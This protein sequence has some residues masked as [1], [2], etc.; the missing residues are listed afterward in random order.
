M[1]GG[2]MGLNAFSNIPDYVDFCIQ[3]SLTP[4]CEIFKDDDTDE[5]KVLPTASNLMLYEAYFDIKA[6]TFNL[7]TICTTLAMCY[8]YDPGKA[9][10]TIENYTTLK[11]EEVEDPSVFVTGFNGVSEFVKLLNDDTTEAEFMRL[12]TIHYMNGLFKK[13]ADHM[14]EELKMKIDEG[15]GTLPIDLTPQERM[16]FGELKAKPVS[17]NKLRVAKNHKK[18]KK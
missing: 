13:V 15:C 16:L 1:G 2:E 12:A 18:V 4:L 9:I 17:R 6:E 7:K 10:N 14:K 8:M 5:L 3:S 11:K